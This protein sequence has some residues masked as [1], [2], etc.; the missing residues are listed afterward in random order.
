MQ[1]PLLKHKSL[2]E[3]ENPAKTDL[4][5][6]IEKQRLKLREFEGKSVPDHQDNWVIIQDEEGKDSA[7]NSYFKED[8]FQSIS[9]DDY[10]QTGISWRKHLVSFKHKMIQVHAPCSKYLL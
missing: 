6:F 9:P 2:W 1:W 3:L 7:E 5:E 10:G 4:Q 8:H